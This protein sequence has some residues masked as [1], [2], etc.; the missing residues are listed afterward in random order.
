LS[1]P[2]EKRAEY[3]R[4]KSRIV[5]PE[6]GPPGDILSLARLLAELNREFGL[7]QTN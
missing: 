6:T 1:L 3:A 4:R 7:W 5:S 2:P